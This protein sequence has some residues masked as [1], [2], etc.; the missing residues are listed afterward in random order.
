MM[1]IAVFC[2]ARA[3]FDTATT[4]IDRAL[5]LRAAWIADRTAIGG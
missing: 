4:L 1:R 3:D 5:C 2:E